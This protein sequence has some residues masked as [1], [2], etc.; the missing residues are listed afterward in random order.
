[1]RPSPLILLAALVISAFSM[2]EARDTQENL[3]GRE[4]T[5]A[6]A[7]AINEM[8]ASS[9][10]KLLG[11]DNVTGSLEVGKLADLICITVQTHARNFP[12]FKACFAV[13][14]AASREGVNDAM[15]NGKLLLRDEKYCILDITY[16]LRRM[17]YRWN[18]LE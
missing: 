5:A 15:V 7:P 17:L 12:R 13:V 6:S 8:A 1:M 4:A 3:L 16:T 11:V 9:G 18:E 10:T 2:N 14:Y